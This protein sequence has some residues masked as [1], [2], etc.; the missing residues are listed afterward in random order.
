[1]E[2]RIYRSYVS[3]ALACLAASWGGKIEA[4]YID[5]IDP[6]EADEEA[7]TGDEVALDVI[8][9]CGLKAYGN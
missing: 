8:E 4:R 1:M 9:K 3:D 6:S 2:E 7:L 5:L